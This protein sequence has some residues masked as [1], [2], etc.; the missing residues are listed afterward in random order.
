MKKLPTLLLAAI[1][2]LQVLAFTACEKTADPAHV[3]PLVTPTP[4]HVDPLVTPTPDP[5]PAVSNDSNSIV[6][7]WFAEEYGYAYESF[8]G[9]D[10]EFYSIAG[11][12]MTDEHMVE[13]QIIE[14]KY[15]V[16]GDDVFYYIER[17]IIYN[18]DVD[19]F[20]VVNNT[21]EM[22]A[23][24][25]VEGDKLIFEDVGEDFVYTLGTPSGRWDYGRVIDLPSFE[26][27]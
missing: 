13:L 26:G 4:A 12:V 27:R 22:A 21:E 23:T 20:F 25:R 6:G 24:F 3:D 8:Y 10:G 1:L 16:N 14:G 11:E 15:L 17:G 7:A 2:A 9:E 19:L 18:P 5:E